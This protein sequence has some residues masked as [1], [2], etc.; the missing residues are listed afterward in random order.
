[1]SRKDKEFEIKDIQNAIELREDKI[2]MLNKQVS[3]NRKEL[4]ELRK[5]LAV[6]LVKL[7]SK[8]NNIQI[9]DHAMIRYIERVLG[10]NV[11]AIKEKILTQ[12]VLDA[13]K[14]GATS[15]TSNGAKL[16]I[17]NNTIITIV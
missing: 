1:M 11:K 12:T 13:I 17:K 8:P 16:T 9:T 7:N 6:I 5:K 2:N 4:N 15:V 10:V 14:L 3:F